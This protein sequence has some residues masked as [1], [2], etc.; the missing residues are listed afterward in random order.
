MIKVLCPKCKGSGYV[1]HDKWHNLL[2][3]FKGGWKA[4]RG[5]YTPNPQLFAKHFKD[6][7]QCNKTGVWNDD[8]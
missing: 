6:C 5:I 1:P 4:L 3:S 2:V 7:P 8:R